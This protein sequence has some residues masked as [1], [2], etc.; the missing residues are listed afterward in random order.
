MPR[1]TTTT[2]AVDGCVRERYCRG[3]CE[4]HYRRFKKHGDPLGTAP[5]KPR[6]RCTKA[7]CGRLHFARGLCHNHYH[8]WRRAN[9]P[10]SHP[11][12]SVA[13]CDKPAVARDLCGTHYDRRNKGGDPHTM[14]R[15]ELPTE[16][17]FWSFVDKSKECWL[18]TGGTNFAPFDYGH[19]KVG[20]ATVR[21]HRFSYELHKGPIPEGMSVCHTCD[22]PRCVNPDHLWL[23]TPGENTADMDAK[24]RRKF[25]NAKLSPAQ[26]RKLRSLHASKGMTYE[27][28]GRLFGIR[29]ATARMIVLRRTWKNVD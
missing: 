3:Y 2:C 6:R 17:R 11:K 14:S 24:G 12:C 20:G 18:W 1:V 15:R 27:A 29:G 16:E 8:Q 28:L 4:R 19:F 9:R 7:G 10:A 25:A 5:Q 26:V 22:T 23:G 21:A 13:W